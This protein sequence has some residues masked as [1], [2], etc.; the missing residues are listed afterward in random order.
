M[1]DLELAL[2]Y[3]E[4]VVKAAEKLTYDLYQET[5]YTHSIV[6]QKLDVYNSDNPHPQDSD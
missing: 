4:K 6:R 1:S 3:R 2:I 5:K